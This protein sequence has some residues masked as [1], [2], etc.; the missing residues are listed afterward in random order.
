MLKF[1]GIIPARGGSKGIPNKNMIDLAGEPLL[2]YTLTESRKSKYLDKVILSSDDE[3]IIEYGKSLGVEAPFKRPIKFAEDKSSMISVIEHAI[4]WLKE[5]QKYVPDAIMLLQPTSPLRTAEHIDEAIK[6]FE[7]EDADSLISVS[8]PQEHPMEMVYFQN[9]LLK[10]V[11]N[12][13][14]KEKIQMRQ[15]YQE[16]YFINGAI[17]ISKIDILLKNKHFKGGKIIPFFM[18]TLDSIDIDTEDDLK[19]A[20]CLLKDKIK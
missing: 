15:N 12:R 8:R 17:Y 18:E 13:N 6:K 11:V 9:N 4:N 1:L 5:N 2:Y 3:T 19:I 7:E 20:D 10:F 16:C 14:R